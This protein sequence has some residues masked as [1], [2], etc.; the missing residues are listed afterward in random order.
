MSGRDIRQTSGGG[1]Q[2]AKA[3]TVIK[4]TRWQQTLSWKALVAVVAV[5]GA[6][7]WL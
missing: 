5:K 1:G 2:G 3:A 6:Q 4:V 7:L